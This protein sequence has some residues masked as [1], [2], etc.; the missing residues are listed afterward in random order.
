MP[1]PAEVAGRALGKA[2]A[3]R[4]R[5][6]FSVA[7]QGVLQSV[8]LGPHKLHYDWSEGTLELYDRVAD[9]DETADLSTALADVVEELWVQLRPEVEALDPLLTETPVWPEIDGG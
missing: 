9:P 1:I 5:F 7:R 3:E 8:I 4:T 2:S 6:Q